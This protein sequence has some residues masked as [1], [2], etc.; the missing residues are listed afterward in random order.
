MIQHFF[1]IDVQQKMIFF[2]Q[3]LERDQHVTLKTGQNS[4]KPAEAT[5]E[6]TSSTPQWGTLLKKFKIHLFSRSPFWF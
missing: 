2:L 3:S 4:L 5:Q 1:G 6:S